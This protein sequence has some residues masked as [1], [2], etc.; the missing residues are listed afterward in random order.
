MHAYADTLDTLIEP[1]LLLDDRYRLV[2]TIAAGGMGIVYEG[3]Q[4]SIDR[5]VAI[6]VI[7]E[8]LLEDATTARRF[9]REVR[10]LTSFRHPN[11]VEIFDCGQMA[12]GCPY[13]VMELL[14]GKTL[15]VL[16]KE[17]GH[18]DI[19]L[20]CEIAMQLCDVLEAAHERGIIHRD[21]KPANIV[22]LD[23]LGIIKV[24]DFGIAKSLAPE[25]QSDNITHV[26]MMIGT[27]A[28]MAPEAIGGDAVDP[29][30]DLYAL[31]CILHELLGGVPPF[32]APSVGATLARQL[33]APPPPLPG[34]VPAALG[35]LVFELLA[36][37]PEER[38]ASAR[39]VR[40]RLA[41]CVPLQSF[42]DDEVPTLIRQTPSHTQIIVTVE[43]LRPLRI[44]AVLIAI[45]L[46]LALVVALMP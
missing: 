19:W 46:V 45:A 42:A 26:G 41:S 34:D 1:S 20:V 11:V 13:L 9:L 6:K 44:L 2:G 10:L 29:R 23:G 21:L 39:V 24:L 3:V 22:M 25:Y 31:G 7:R 32:E 27:P 30:S 8:E 38:P 43:P 18:L 4:L 35:E 5:P 28:Y 15:D 37:S 36:K 17:V 14:R 33:D 12:N 16:L 40:S